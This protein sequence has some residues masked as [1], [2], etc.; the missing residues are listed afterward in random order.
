LGC[1]IV[2]LIADVYCSTAV[3]DGASASLLE[4]IARVL[5]LRTWREK[6]A[7]VDEA[8]FSSPLQLMRN[9]AFIPS[10]KVDFE[11]ATTPDFVDNAE[12]EVLHLLARRAIDTTPSG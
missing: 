9:K 4:A 11:I 10:W 12:G 3:S 6:R 2:I 5:A 1:I 7:P 8:A